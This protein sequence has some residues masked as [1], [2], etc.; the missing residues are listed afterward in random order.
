MRLKNLVEWPVVVTVST[1]VFACSSVDNEGSSTG[2]SSASTM[3]TSSNGS[4]GGMQQGGG[5]PAT[6]GSATVLFF[7][8]DVVPIFENSCGTA[9]DMCHS[10]KAFGADLTAGCIGWLSLENK[11]LG[12]GCPDMDLYERLLL[13]SWQCYDESGVA[14]V[15]P[16]D[17]DNSYLVQKMEG[18]PLCDLET[19][20]GPKTSDPMPVGAN[21]DPAELDIIRQWI[22]GGAQRIDGTGFDCGAGAGGAGGGGS[23]AGPATTT[24]S[25]MGNQNP[26]A[27][28]DH[29]V[30]GQPASSGEPLQFSGIGT[31]PQDGDLPGSS[32]EWWSSVDGYIG[33]GSTF[34]F[35][36]TTLGSHTIELVATD[37]DDNK[38]YATVNVNVQ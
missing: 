37:S 38:G 8:S 1:I 10:K 36:L 12:A 6:G 22:A 34:D 11:P 33:A 15:T 29:P 19:P 28:I 24:G 35:A 4:G 20:D 26:S 5:S 23:G 31:D 30:D 25:S 16:C 9:D 7:E 13:Q 21:V 17:P 32:L 27:E 2:T 14:Y 18:A 3:G